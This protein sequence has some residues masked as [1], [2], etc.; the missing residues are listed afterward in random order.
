MSLEPD[1]GTTCALNLDGEAV[2]GRPFTVTII[3]G[4]IR[5]ARSSF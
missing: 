1:E 4:V 2:E 5:V 3:P